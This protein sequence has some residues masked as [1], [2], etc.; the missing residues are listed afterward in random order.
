[1]Q[2]LCGNGRRSRMDGGGD[3]EGGTLG[4]GPP[5]ESDGGF[6]QA[7]LSHHLIVSWICFNNLSILHIIFLDMVEDS[8]CFFLTD[9]H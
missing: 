3:G 1:M 8:G 6:R 2:I 7:C 5:A 9:P 4:R